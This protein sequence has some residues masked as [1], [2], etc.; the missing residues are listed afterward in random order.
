M[1]E[2]A[3]LKYIAVIRD[4]GEGRVLTI[5]ADR[6]RVTIE[7]ET[8]IGSTIIGEYTS[9]GTAQRAAKLAEKG[10]RLP[11]NREAS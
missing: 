7:H 9:L 1:T 2:P 11:A 4:G 6:L 5:T 3:P 10:W 8:R